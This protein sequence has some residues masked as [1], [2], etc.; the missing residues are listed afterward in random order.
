MYGW[1]LEKRE[2]RRRHRRNRNGSCEI[3]SS[4]YSEIEGLF[5]SEAE[6]IKKKKGLAVAS[7]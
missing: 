4:Y 3:D 6:I 1:E 7:M 2:N 5:L